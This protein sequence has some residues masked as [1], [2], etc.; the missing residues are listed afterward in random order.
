MRDFLSMKGRLNRLRYFLHELVISGVVTIIVIGVGVATD[1]Y[2]VG[3]P[4]AA[5][6]FVLTVGIGASILYVFQAVKRLHDLDRPGSH[7]WLLLIPFYNIY[8]TLV[9]HFK[10]GTDGPNHYGPDPLSARI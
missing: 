3:Y 9:L 7:Y 5:G 10:R 2:R 6:L 1:G 4:E 8:L